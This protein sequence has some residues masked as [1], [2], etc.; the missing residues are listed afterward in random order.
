MGF[1]KQI[2][3][4]LAVDYISERGA[5]GALEDLGSIASGV[6]NLFSS[7]DDSSNE[8]TPLSD[9]YQELIDQ[10]EYQEAIDLINQY[11]QGD[12]KDYLYKS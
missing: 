9:T 12:K 2:V 5:K 6:K 7:E 11:Y 3:K 8:G 10:E 4:D 1:F